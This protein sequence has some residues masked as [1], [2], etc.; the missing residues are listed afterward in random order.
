MST[1][2][3]IV[4]ST[5]EKLLFRPV[6]ITGVEAVCESFRLLSMQG[7]GFQLVKWTPGHTVQI[8]LGNFVK[9]AYTP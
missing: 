8:F 7:A 1:L 6:T 3:R 9:R 2:S 4:S 5:V